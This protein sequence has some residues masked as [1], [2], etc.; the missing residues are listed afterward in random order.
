[1]QTF[2]QFTCGFSIKI[3]YGLLIIVIS[4]HRKTTQNLGYDNKLRNTKLGYD[5]KLRNTKTF[6]M[7]DLEEKNLNQL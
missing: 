7:N 4:L 6:I 2:A 3:I 5:N 1:M